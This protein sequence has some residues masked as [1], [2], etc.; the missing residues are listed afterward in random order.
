MSK[1]NVAT[2][3]VVSVESQITDAFAHLMGLITPL[4]VTYKDSTQRSI[5]APNEY[6]KNLLSNACANQSFTMTDC[7]A[8]LRSIV[9]GEGS[10][11]AVEA[12]S[13]QEVEQAAKDAAKAYDDLFNARRAYAQIKK[14]PE[15]FTLESF[16]FID[17]ALAEK[18][19]TNQAWKMRQT[20]RRKEAEE[21]KGNTS[22][23]D[24][25]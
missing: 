21:A 18:K 5:I 2:V 1:S 3:Q 15:G 6:L 23:A 7:V 12:L 13:D 22:P 4:G 16:L 14:M 9:A 8:S 24:A 17:D 19:R 11:S 25:I 20:Q 10:Q